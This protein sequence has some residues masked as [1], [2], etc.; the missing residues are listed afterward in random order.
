MSRDYYVAL[1]EGFILAHNPPDRI[2]KAFRAIIG[3][4]DQMEGWIGGSAPSMPQIPEIVLRGTR[5]PWSQGELKLLA[6][7]YVSKT[8][9]VEEIARDLA[10]TVEAVHQKA[11][12]MKLKRPEPEEEILQGS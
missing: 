12:Q 1:V 10:R 5:R 9:S 11:F 3:G 4:D 8:V 6:K 7:L 2:Y